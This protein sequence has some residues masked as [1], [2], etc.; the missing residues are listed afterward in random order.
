MAALLIDEVVVSAMGL[1][2]VQLRKVTPND[3]KPTSKTPSDDRLVRKTLPQGVISAAI[4][5][6]SKRRASREI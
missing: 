6:I 2:P 4:P 1:F 3:A 5:Y